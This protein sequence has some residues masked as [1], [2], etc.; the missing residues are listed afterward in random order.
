M[1]RYEI[2]L[3]IQLGDIEIHIIADTDNWSDVDIYQNSTCVWK[4]CHFK[5]TILMLVYEK[6]VIRVCKIN[7]PTNRPTITDTNT[8]R[9]WLMKPIA[10]Y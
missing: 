4:N 8:A 1:H 9:M 5:S 3:I 6:N 10:D 2:L 7:C